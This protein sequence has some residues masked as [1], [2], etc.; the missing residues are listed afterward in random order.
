MFLQS[1]ETRLAEFKDLLAEKDA[2]IVQVAEEKESEIDSLKREVENLHQQ[3][4][5]DHQ[6]SSLFLEPEL[7]SS[8]M[9]S[10]QQSLRSAPSDDESS[11]RTAL[12]KAVASI[13]K[14]LVDNSQGQDDSLEQQVNSLKTN[15]ENTEVSRNTLL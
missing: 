1:T 15:L 12:L 8:Q 13:D 10:L 11:F 5:S 2:E 9:K 4:P 7:Q 6:L 14:S 3:Q